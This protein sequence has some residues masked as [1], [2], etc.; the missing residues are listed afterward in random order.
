MISSLTTGRMI[1]P[2]TT[3]RMIQGDIIL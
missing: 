1:S 2:L 3:G